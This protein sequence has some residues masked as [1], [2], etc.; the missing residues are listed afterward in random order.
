MYFEST[1]KPGIDRNPTH[2]RDARV[3]LIGAL[4]V[5]GAAL[6]LIVPLFTGGLIALNAG[7]VA[8]EDVRATRSL[9]FT[10]N[11]LTE[12]AR[13]EAESAVPIQYDPLDLRVPRQQVVRARGVIDYL[14]AVRADPIA[15][16]ADK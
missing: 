14:R 1:G 5:L 9:S 7:D 8:R 16:R 2:W 12:Q 15:S 3:W 11:S 4:F 13:A 10:S 6:I